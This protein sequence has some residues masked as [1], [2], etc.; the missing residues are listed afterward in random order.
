MREFYYFWKFYYPN[1]WCPAYLYPR[2]NM[3]GEYSMSF[4]FALMVMQ[5]D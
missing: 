2:V 1:E 4:D 3:L 5:D